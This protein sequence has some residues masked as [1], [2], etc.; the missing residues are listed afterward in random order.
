MLCLQDHYRGVAT[1]SGVGGPV[2]VRYKTSM[3]CITIECHP[4]LTQNLAPTRSLNAPNGLCFQ[5]SLMPVG[6]T[7][8]R[9]QKP[10]PLLRPHLHA[11]T[12]HLRASRLT[13]SRLAL[14]E[15]CRHWSPHRPRRLAH[16]ASGPVYDND[17]KRRTSRTSQARYDNAC[18]SRRPPRTRSRDMGYAAAAVPGRS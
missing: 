1:I 17:A 9:L 2:I 3:L 12:R 8:A 7:A 15:G 4:I 10:S 6:L 11:L 18:H 16:A 13:Q 14:E 5:H